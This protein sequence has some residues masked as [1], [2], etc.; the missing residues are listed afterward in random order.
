MREF[1][2]NNGRT[3]QISVTVGAVGRVRDATGILIPSLFDDNCRPLAELSA[4][5]IQLVN[6]I[7]CLCRK[8]AESSGVSADDFADAL[9]GDALGAAG[10]AVVRATADFFTSPEQREA[11][12]KALDK[13]GEIAR[14]WATKATE[15]VSELNATQVARNYLDCATN[16][17]ASSESTPESLLS[18]N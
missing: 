16:T 6:V 5:V 13:M 3:W 11:A 14:Q 2:D 18:A 9:G 15:M 10:E 4:D 1:T 12:H 17:P 7:F 8:Q